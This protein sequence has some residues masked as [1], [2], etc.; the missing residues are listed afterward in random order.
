V[1]SWVSE[2]AR[3]AGQSASIRR[4]QAART[5]RRDKS[6]LTYAN[7]ENP[8]PEAARLR[9][10]TSRGDEV[11]NARIAIPGQQK[12]LRVAAE[13][14]EK[15]NWRRAYL[16]GLAALAVVRLNFEVNFSTRP[17]VSTRRFSPV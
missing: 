9:G 13:G 16:A 8:T 15:E 7:Q 3:A 1:H 5:S 12:A 6:S 11:R 10:H 2:Q 4:R 17:A 14:G